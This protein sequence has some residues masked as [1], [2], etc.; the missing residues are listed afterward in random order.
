MAGVSDR[1]YSVNTPWY[2]APF[3]ECRGPLHAARRKRVIHK[4]DNGLYCSWA[5]G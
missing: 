1:Q 2:Q 3:R 5:P 4:P